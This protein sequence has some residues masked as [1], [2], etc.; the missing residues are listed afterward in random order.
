MEG[1]SL[2][3]V[4]PL[5]T[6]QQNTVFLSGSGHPIHTMWMP[7]LAQPCKLELGLFSQYHSPG[8][9]YDTTIPPPPRFRTSHSSSLRRLHRWSNNPSPLCACG[10][11]KTM[12]HIIETCPLQRLN[13]GL[14][15]P[16]TAEQETIT[17]LE[18]F[19]F[20]K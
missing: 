13:G 18:D 8:S 5:H 9:L 14:T 3:T 12:E 6:L 17:W 2:H 10:E 19:A 15:T 20:S 1:S 11:E 16:P 7:S 4:Y